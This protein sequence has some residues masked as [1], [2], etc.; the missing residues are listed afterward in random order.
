MKG[1]EQSLSPVTQ[2]PSQAI[3]ASYLSFLILSI[4]IRKMGILM[5]TQRADAKMTKIIQIKLA[6]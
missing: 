3:Q 2:P 6:Q 4:H 5:T 1:K